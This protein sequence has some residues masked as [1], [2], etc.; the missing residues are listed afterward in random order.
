MALF[1]HDYYYNSLPYAVYYWSGALSPEQQLHWAKEALECYSTAEH[2]NLSNLSRLRAAD[3]VDA[4]ADC[5]DS[6]ADCADA[7]TAQTASRPEPEKSSGSSG[8][9]IWRQAVQANDGLQSL[10]GLRW[11]YKI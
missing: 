7:D 2:T 3:C 5:I 8:R 6:A 11:Y 9:D 4:A 1:R 10:M